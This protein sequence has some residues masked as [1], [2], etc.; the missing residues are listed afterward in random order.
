MFKQQRLKRHARICDQVLGTFDPRLDAHITDLN[1]VNRA[2]P[3]KVASTKAD[4]RRNQEAVAAGTGQGCKDTLLSKAFGAGCREVASPNRL[5][6]GNR[7]A[8]D[9]SDIGHWTRKADS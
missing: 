6:A 8:T 9:S 2:D 1:K 5:L 4:T 3:S 7:T